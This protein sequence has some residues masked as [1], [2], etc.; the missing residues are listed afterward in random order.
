MKTSEE[1]RNAFLNFWKERPR[2]SK[3][4]PNASLVPQNDPTLL[5]V[6]SGMFPIVPYLAGQPHPLG[7]RLH[8]VQRCIRTKDI[9]DVGDNR[10]LVMFE[11][12]GNWSLGDFS[13]AEQIPW[14]LEL[15]VN[16]FGI[17]PKRLYITVWGG[18]DVVGRDDEAINLWIKAFKDICGMEVEFS[19]D[20][21]NI[22]K[23]LKEGEDWKYRIFP[24][25][26]EANWWERAH[27]ENELGG[28]SSELFYD[29]G[30]KER[31]QDKYHIND[32]SG[33]FVEVGNNVFMEYKLDAQLVYRPLEK[34]N[35]DFGGGF[36]RIIIAA[37]NKYDA[38][39]TDLFEPM[40]KRVEEITG[41][42]YKSGIEIDNDTKAFRVISEHARSSTFILA[43]GVK[44]GNKDQSYILRRLIRRMVRYGKNLN[45]EQNFTRDLASVVIEKMKDAYPHLKENERFILDEIDAE[46]IKFRKTLDR[47]L[48]EFRRMMGIETFKKGET[49][50]HEYITLSGDKAFDLYET[51]GFPLELVIEEWHQINKEQ[52]LKI[53]EQKE[54][55]L[56]HEFKKEEEKHRQ[57]SRAGSEQKFKGGLAD[58]SVETTKL[59]T[60]HHLLL[61]ALQ[62]LIDPNIKQRGSNITSER[63]RIDFNFDRKLTEEEVKQIEDLVNDQI[64]NSLNVVRIEMPKEDAEKIGA[65]MEFGQK[66]PD[67]VSVYLIAPLS[68]INNADWSSDE[69]VSKEFCGGPHVSNTNEIGA[70]NKKFKITAQE[71]VGAGIKRIK[72]SLV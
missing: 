45:I 47:G 36:D 51:Y 38:Y 60:A 27:A 58:Q 43:D 40:I 69:I 32:D 9:E 7:T 66:Y 50:K 14:C 52:N 57:A 49:I 21:T 1:I 4:I 15:Y 26:R 65:Q 22:P 59:H 42:K 53:P 3:V 63:L 11:M 56:I 72:A 48:K 55:D 13:K 37:Q 23:D 16:K 20:I 8:N 2:N 25:G 39:S 17:D 12:I 41:K 29:L 44:P 54:I 64:L 33:R 6:N 34:K 71:N 5:F 28:P 31:D 30:E 24:Y 19:E 18:D 67:I 68:I 62:K 61:A 10:H 35:I 46:E 70:G